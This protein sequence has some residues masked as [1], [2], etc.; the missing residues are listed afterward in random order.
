MNAT[1]TIIPTTR[2]L[3]AR[4]AL[5][6]DFTDL[7]DMLR[8]REYHKLDVVVPE[9]NVVFRDGLLIV[10]GVEPVLTEDGVVEVSGTYRLTPHAQQQ[11]A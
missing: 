11:L 6:A 7:V 9:C 10:G 2:E 1:P 3:P 8:L 5:R 4:S